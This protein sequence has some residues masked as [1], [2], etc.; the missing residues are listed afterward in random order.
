MSGQG[1]IAVLVSGVQLALAVLDAGHSDK[2]ERP[3]SLAAQGLWGLA[4]AGTVICLA[5]LKHLT[6]HPDYA[7]VLAPLVQREEVSG[8]REVT[9]KVLRKNL[10]VEF[11]VAFVFVVT[12]VSTVTDGSLTSGHL[13]SHYDN[14]HISAEASTVVP[15][16]R[17]VHCCP[18]PHV[19]QWV[20]AVAILT[21][22]LAISLVE[23]TSRPF[24]A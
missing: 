10:R 17:G 14:D 4:A 2:H 23:R 5:A 12:L 1:G 18:F 24:Q 11:A 8:K 21:H 9:R 20:S 13:P 7:A 6:E 19:Q 3:S 16:A 22:Q 15:P